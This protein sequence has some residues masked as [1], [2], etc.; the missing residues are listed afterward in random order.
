MIPLQS[1]HVAEYNSL[2]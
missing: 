1:K 2:H